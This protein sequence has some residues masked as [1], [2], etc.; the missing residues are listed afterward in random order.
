MKKQLALIVNK[1]CNIC[2]HCD[3]DDEFISLVC[4][5][6]KNRVEDKFLCSEFEV[7]KDSLSDFIPI[8][9]IIEHE[10]RA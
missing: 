4:T 10:K 6:Y 5:K 8:E 7:S 1:S 3:V 9:E 2:K